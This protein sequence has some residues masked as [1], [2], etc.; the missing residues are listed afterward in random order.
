MAI[1]PVIL[2]RPSDRSLFLTAAVVFPL[3]ILVGYFKSYYFNQFFDVKP[4]ANTLVHVHG[5]VMSLWVVFFTVQIALVRTKNIKLHM[6]LGIFG[7]VLAAIVVIVGLATGYDSH[8]V[9]RTAPPGLNPHGF[10][11]IGVADMLLFVIFLSGAIYFRKKAAEH[12]ALMLMTAFNFLP[13]AFARI[14][15][16][17]EKYMILWSLGMPD[18]LA[19][20]CLVW[21]S[22]KRRKFQKVF[23][24]GILLLIVSQP[25]RIFFAGTEIWLSFVARIAP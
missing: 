23:A 3:L 17:P 2:K 6:T 4:I 20:I 10:F 18:L 19:I 7:V 25:F 9:R 16:V 21:M 24:L 14:H 11:L 5:I 15:L 22:V 8:V 1:N 12:K 13:A